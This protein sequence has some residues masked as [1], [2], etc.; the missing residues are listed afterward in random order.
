MN[1]WAVYNQQGR[2]DSIYSGPDFEAQLQAQGGLEVVLI[3]DDLDDVTA[4]ISGGAV[5][6]KQPI[7][8]ITTNTPL[9]ADGTDEVIIS[10]IPP[11]VQVQWPDGQTDIVTDGEIRFSVDFPGTYTFQF[12]AVPYLDKEIT[13]EAIA[14]T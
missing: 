9:I 14:A 6:P 5:Q 8:L 12:T 2:I 4:Y 3:A 10:G 7:S 11:G 1:R 13:V